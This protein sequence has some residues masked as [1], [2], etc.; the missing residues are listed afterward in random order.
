MPIAIPVLSI[1]LE[2]EV[3]IAHFTSINI[4]YF[5]IDFLGVEVTRYAR[6]Y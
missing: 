5:S 3:L 2:R 6:E 1:I 4:Q